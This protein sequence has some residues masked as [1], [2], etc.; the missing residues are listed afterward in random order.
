MTSLTWSD[1]QGHRNRRAW[2]LIIY[3]DT[4]T[5]FSGQSLPGTVAVVDSRY[6]KNGKWSHTTYQL[7]LADKVTAIAGTDGWEDGTFREGLAAATGKPTSRWFDL[8]NTLGVSLTSAQQWLRGWRPKA[9]E[10]Y[11][12]VET[13]L[14]SVGDIAPSGA[15]EISISFGSPTR[16]LRERGYWSWPISIVTSNGNIV[17]Q[18]TPEQY[19]VAGQY[20]PVAVT[21]FSQAS[22]HGGGSVTVK[23]AVPDGCHATHEE[24]EVP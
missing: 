23:L 10:H 4:I 15:T 1:Q 5:V 3:H 20:G 16:K 8:A 2:L 17:A 14:A 22:G 12:E 9:A 11:D 19:Q 6:S 21:N 7:E 24:S 13:M 18:L